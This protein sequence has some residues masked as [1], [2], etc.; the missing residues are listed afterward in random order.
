MKMWVATIIPKDNVEAA[1]KSRKQRGLETHG[2]PIGFHRVTGQVVR[3][4]NNKAKLEAWAEEYI[5][6][7]ADTE[8][9]VTLRRWRPGRNRKYQ[10]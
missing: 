4:S 10:T 9:T 2:N 8:F 1:T 5:E 7:H 3:S 6:Q